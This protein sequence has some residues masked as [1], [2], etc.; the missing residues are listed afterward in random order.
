VEKVLTTA[1]ADDTTTRGEKNSSF[2]GQVPSFDAWTQEY[3]LLLLGCHGLNDQ[4]ALSN[5]FVDEL[6]FPH[7]L[8]RSI[9]NF[10]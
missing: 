2:I 5:E 10:S 1:L 7:G 4:A 9:L 6:S 8:T 3:V